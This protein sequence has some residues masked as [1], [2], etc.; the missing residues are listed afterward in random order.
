[1]ATKKKDK[2]RKGYSCMRWTE[3][4]NQLLRDNFCSLSN[5]ELG[6]MFHPGRTEDAVR[7]QLNTLKLRRPKKSELKELE[8]KAGKNPFFQSLSKGKKLRK[9]NEEALRKKEKQEK[10]RE[11]EKEWARKVHGIGAEEKPKAFKQESE[12]GKVW[13]TLNDR[14]RMLVPRGKEDFYR[15]KF[16]K[17]EE[18]KFKL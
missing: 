15:A 18:N 16:N 10:S 12:E 5:E 11:K 17:Y 7:K 8:K 14:T 4:D 9:E 13:I 3:A 6:A 1:M 2:K